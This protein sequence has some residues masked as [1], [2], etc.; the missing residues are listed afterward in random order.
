MNKLNKRLSVTDLTTDFINVKNKTPLAII[1]TS[2]IKQE[3]KDFSKDPIIHQYVGDILKGVK[4]LPFELLVKYM[5]L[6]LSLDEKQIFRK[7]LHHQLS[8]SRRAG[9]KSKEELAEK[10]KANYVRIFYL[11]HI[12]SCQKL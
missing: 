1:F 8:T 6:N 2:I 9:L 7:M 5:R 10:A 4:N 12:F 3:N 11:F